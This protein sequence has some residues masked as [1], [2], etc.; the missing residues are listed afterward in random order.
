MKVLTI[1]NGFIANHLPYKIL[2]TRVDLS[3]KAIDNMLDVNKPDVLINAIG[4]CGRPNVDQCE[5]MKE[6]TSIT[7]T[8]L[9]ILLA[10]ACAKKSIHL[11][12]IGS[13]CIFFGKSPNYAM[14]PGY[15]SY[16]TGSNE[17]MDTGWKEDDFAN[18]KSYY[19][20]SKYACD[21]MLGGFSNVTTLRIRIPISTKNNPRNTINKLI[22]Y[23]QVIDIPNS[24]TFMHNLVSCV[25]WAIKQS[26]T[27]TFHVVNPQPLTPAQIM[28]EYQK[29][30]PSHSFEIIDE[31]QLDKIMIA[32]RSNCIINGDKLKK[33]GFIMDPSEDALKRC[34]AEYIKNI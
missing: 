26:K 24:M 31:V 3:S 14:P 32:K 1:G 19:S 33:A 11:I 25:D 27:G 29:Y 4:F 15:N 16:H 21:L 12:Q 8:A 18:P 17:W 13:G 30:V 10:D 2:D 5:V 7:N 9:P 6:K 34:M 23:K 20:K 22:N 28:R